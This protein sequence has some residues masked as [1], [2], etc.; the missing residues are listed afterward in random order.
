MAIVLLAAL[1]LAIRLSY[2]HTTIVDHP[3]R[4]DVRQYFAY[5]LNLANNHVFS[6]AT[7]GQPPIP[8]SFRDPGY[9][10]FLALVIAIFGSEQAFYLATL[11]IQAVMAAATVLIYVLL[12]RRWMGIGAALFVGIGLT[13]WPHTITLP[14]YI[15]S[16][17]LMG[18][19]L[20][21]GLFFTD[22]AARRERYTWFAIAGFTLALAAL[23]NSIFTPVTPLFALIAMWRNKPSRRLWTVFLVATLVPLIGW[24]LRNHFLPEGQKSEDRVA[25]NFVQ[26]SWPQY[27]NAW[28][29][30]ILNKDEASTSV[31]Q[32]MEAE[33]SLFQEAPMRGMGAV[34]SRIGASPVPYVMWYASKP[35]E[36]WGWNI[37]IG[38]GDIYVFPVYNSPLSTPGVMKTATDIMFLIAPLIL[39][40]A[41]VGLVVI[42]IDW[43]SMPAALCL[44]AL[45]ALVLTVVCA[46]LQSDAR[47][48]APYRGVEWLLAGL[49]LH[50]IARWRARLARVA[51]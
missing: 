50:T 40:L 31:M 21:L 16:E 35:V 24:A 45:A 14:G 17:T 37:G 2:V 1:A 3:L 46:L 11:D 10:I 28:K 25:I 12:A 30:S 19:L 4:G 49:S 7:P 43:R 39:L 33:Y 47:Y 27:H 36:L 32:Q 5:A 44:G 8:D 38:D 23:T 48:A 26:G 18:L 9:P 15:L 41:V 29:S 13:L 51:S 20:A 22:E 42:A 34:A 6:L